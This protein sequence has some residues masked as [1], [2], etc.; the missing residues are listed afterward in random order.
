MHFQE[1]AALLGAEFFDHL[2]KAALRDDN[3]AGQIQ[4]VVEFLDIG[5]QGAGT[6]AWERVNLRG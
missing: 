2:A 6:G 5:A 1:G 3:F 4:H